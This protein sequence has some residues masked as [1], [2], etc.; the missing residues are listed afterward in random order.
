MPTDLITLQDPRSQYPGPPT[1]VEIQPAPAMQ[2]IHE[3]KA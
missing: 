1:S 3:R 2:T